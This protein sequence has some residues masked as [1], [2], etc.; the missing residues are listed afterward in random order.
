MYNILTLLV[1]SGLFAITA[2]TVRSLTKDILLEVRQ[3]YVERGITLAGW[4][5]TSEKRHPVARQNLGQ[6]RKPNITSVPKIFV[7][8]GPTSL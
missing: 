7:L 2:L 8:H 6:S 1:F 3:L 4:H 5:K